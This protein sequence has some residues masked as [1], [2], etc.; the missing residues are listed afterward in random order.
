MPS[1]SSGSTRTRSRPARETH[2]HRT[3]KVIELV[4]SSTQGFEDA[5][6]SGL[7][8][9]RQNLRGITGARV[10]GLSVRCQDGEVVEYKADLAVAFGI[11]RTPQ[12]GGD[13][14]SG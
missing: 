3:A 7:A 2:E 14:S 13:G 8:D 12:A 11:E 10:R 1:T 5:I 6:R 9:A 4:S